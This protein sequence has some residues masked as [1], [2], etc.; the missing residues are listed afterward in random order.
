MDPKTKIFGEHD[1]ATIKQIETCVA[2]GGERAVL[3][4]DGHKGYAQPIGG[5]V[6]YTAKISLS[7][8]GFDIACGNLAIRTDAK[9]Q[10]I[11]PKIDKIMDDVVREISFGI[12]RKSKTRVEHE[13]F[14]DPAWQLKPI[15]D[16][17]SIAAEQLGTVGGGNHYVDIFADEQE[18]IWV[19]VHFGSRG[20]GHKTATYFLQQGGAKDGMDVDPLVIDVASPLGS[21]YLACMQ[22]AGRYAYAGRDWVCS[23]VAR[24]LG[25]QILEEVHNH[26]NYA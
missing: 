24:I 14:D 10:E 11:A 3:C 6:A 2:T 4:A 1:P 18:R 9:R 23:E 5:V 8:V 15:G 19:G 13:L 25:A 22:L 12:G 26:H 7:G 17:K 20:L 21:D 16:L